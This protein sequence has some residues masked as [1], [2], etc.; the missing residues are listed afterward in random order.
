MNVNEFWQKK[1][2]ESKKQAGRIT[3]R[4]TIKKILKLNVNFIKCSNCLLMSFPRF[5]PSLVNALIFSEYKAGKLARNGL[6]DYSGL[7]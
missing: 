3:A 4:T 2:C 7:I 6:K 1:S 5:N